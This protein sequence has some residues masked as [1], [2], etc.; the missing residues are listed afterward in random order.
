MGDA[1]RMIIANLMVG[2]ANGMIKLDGGRRN[3]DY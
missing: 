2:D 1:K 3:R